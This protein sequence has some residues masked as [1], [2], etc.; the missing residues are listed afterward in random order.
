MVEPSSPSLLR[1]SHRNSRMDFLVNF[2]G[3]SGPVFGSMLFDNFQY[4]FVFG[5]KPFSRILWVRNFSIN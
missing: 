3:T 2:H 5:F 4:Y 1:V